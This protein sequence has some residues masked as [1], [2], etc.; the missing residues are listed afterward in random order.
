M[1]KAQ[2]TRPDIDFGVLGPLVASVDGTAIRFTGA[3]ERCLLAFLLLHANEMVS[4]DRLIDALWPDDP[5]DDRAQHAPGP[6]VA[7]AE[8]RRLE[9]AC[10]V[11]ER[12]LADGE[13]WESSTSS[14]F[15]SWRERAGARELRRMPPEQQNHCGKPS[16]SGAGSRFR[17]SQRTRSLPSKARALRRSIWPRSKSGSRLSWIAARELLSWQN[18]KTPP[19]R[20]RFASGSWVS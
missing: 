15:A 3:K 6:R 1:V 13:T 9:P 12:L 4:I 16:R 5:P 18:S 10:N 19:R 20:I 8:G 14:A 11:R 7:V 2:P 17:S